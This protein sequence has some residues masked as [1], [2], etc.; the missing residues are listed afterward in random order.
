MSKQLAEECRK[1]AA[2]CAEVAE[3]EEDPV[4]KREYSDLATMWRL[5]ARE[6]EETQSI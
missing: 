3:K 4:R 6:S 1:R 5:I 2:E